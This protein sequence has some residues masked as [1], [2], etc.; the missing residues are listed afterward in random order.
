MTCSLLGKDMDES[1]RFSS[2]VE[3]FQKLC[4]GRPITF[5]NTVYL[6]ERN[7]N[8]TNTALAYLMQSKRAFPEGTVIDDVVEFYT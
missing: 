3:S 1:T 8:D 2:T 7:H 4:G 6:S 5:D